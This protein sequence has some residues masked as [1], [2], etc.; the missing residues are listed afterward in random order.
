MVVVGCVRFIEVSL[1]LNVYLHNIS[2]LFVSV[3]CVVLSI[4]YILCKRIVF[5]S[6]FLKV[7]T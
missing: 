7:A 4:V 6:L 5:D 3:L 1:L 2:F